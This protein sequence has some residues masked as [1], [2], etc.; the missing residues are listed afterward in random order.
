MLTVV[1]EE[2]RQPLVH[3]GDRVGVIA[4]H[5]A[6][7]RAER[8]ASLPAADIEQR[9]VARS[10]LHA[11][12]PFPR[13]EIGARDGHVRVGI[14]D[15]LERSDVVE[16]G[17]RGDAA[18]PVH[19]AALDAALLVRDVVL[20]GHAVIHLPVLEE[21]APRVDVR[22]RLAVI[23]HLVIVRR[24]AI[25]DGVRGSLE[26]PVGVDVGGDLLRLGM[27]ER[28][29]DPALRKLH[30]ARDLLRRDEARRA[31]GLLSDRCPLAPGL[32]LRPPLLVLG[33]ERRRIRWS[34]RRR[35]LRG[36]RSL[37]L[38]PGRDPTHE[39]GHGHTSTH[40]DGCQTNSHVVLHS[41]Q[42]RRSHLAGRQSIHDTRALG[43]QERHC[44]R[45]NRPRRAMT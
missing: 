20:H 6:R 18:L 28:H 45:R 32:E 42:N 2:G 25:G 29:Y 12:F 10:D 33:S 44:R 31:L 3:P 17:A 34:D 26:N 38:C 15:A 16:H 21:V 8:I 23:A 11:G 30:G 27:R 13:F 19:H 22:H 4:R 7:P 14:L 36:R 35:R 24:A 43:L 37:T 39:G 5:L 1:A 9:D 41:V 40:C